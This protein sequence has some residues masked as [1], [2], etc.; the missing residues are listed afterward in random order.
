MLGA[1]TGTPKSLYGFVPSELV[2]KPLESFI[3]VFAEWQA[4][5]GNTRRLLTL[6]GKQVSG[7]EG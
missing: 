1:S 6:M 7:A 2:G 3:D 5:E 4:A